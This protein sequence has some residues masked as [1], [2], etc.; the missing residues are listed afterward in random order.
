MQIDFS[1]K[2]M[3]ELFR[4]IDKLN[5]SRVE[6]ANI[7]EA[8]AR[9]AEKKIRRAAVG[10]ENRELNNIIMDFKKSHGGRYVM[11]GHL[12]NGVTHQYNE[13]AAGGTH[14]GFKNGYVTLAHWVD[15]GTFR[16]PATFFFTHAA[17]ELEKDE[18]IRKAEAIIAADIFERKT[19]LMGGSQ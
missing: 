18:E 14:V 17:Q 5:F 4:K 12:Y 13:T 9:V 19:A 16:Q 10:V 7:V 1:E 11:P 15:G 6:K 2:G 3:D 8:G